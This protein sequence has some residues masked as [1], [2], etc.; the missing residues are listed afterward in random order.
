MKFISKQGNLSPYPFIRVDN[1]HYV[2]GSTFPREGQTQ[3]IF[4]LTHMHSDHLGGL[5]RNW[6][7]ALDWN[8]GVIYC[9]EATY[10]MMLLR[11][12]NLKP[13]LRPV[14]LNTWTDLPVR[15]YVRKDLV[16]KMEEARGSSGNGDKYQGIKYEQSPLAP[17]LLLRPSAT[18][19]NLRLCF[20]D[21]NHCPGA[22]MV[23]I[24]G[25][26]GQVLHTGDFRFGGE[27]MV[28]EV[29]D[30]CQDLAHRPL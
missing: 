3:G 25:P 8:Y 22:V 18:L 4:V 2:A 6:Q 21:A 7:P 12:Q 24:D 23:R 15:E 9:S 16:Q 29:R 28:Q 14:P 17:H 10:N 1:F 26:L 19:C 11:F 5:T 13:F 30:S 20:L 27:R